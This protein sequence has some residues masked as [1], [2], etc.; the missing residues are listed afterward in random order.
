M[1]EFTDEMIDKLKKELNK[2]YKEMAKII[3]RLTNEYK[4][5]T[6][7]IYNEI[8]KDSLEKAIKNVVDIMESSCLPCNISEYI[9][10]RNIDEVFDEEQNRLMG[11]GS[12][13]TNKVWDNLNEKDTYA[14]M[15]IRFQ[16]NE[17]KSKFEF[18]GTEM[19]EDR[20]TVHVCFDKT[21]LKE[22]AE[23]DDLKFIDSGNG[24][25]EVS[26]NI[27]QLEYLLTPANNKENQKLKIYTKDENH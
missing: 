14:S 18:Y 5:N 15:A 3:K 13:L 22:L 12:Q 9:Y 25:I 17:D 6:I 24:R 8:I 20:L 2:R 19:P 23:K 10:Y 27:P 4:K 26:M 7:L 21:F 16:P 11:N 1:S